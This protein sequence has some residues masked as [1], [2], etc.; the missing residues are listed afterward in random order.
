[1][2]SKIVT[3]LIILATL[4]FITTS[5]L[6][7]PLADAVGT[8]FTYQGRLDRDGQAYTGSCD[9]QFSLW[10][11]PSVGSQFGATIDKTGLIVNK[12]LFTT[13][14]DFGAGAFSGDARWLEVS[15]LC[16]G[17]SVYTTLGRQELTPTPYALYAEASPWSGLS[18]VPAG[19][20]DGVDEDTLYDNG[21]GLSLTGTTFSIDPAYI[22]RR[23][24][25]TCAAGSSIQSI[26]EDGT[27]T[28]EVD[29]NTTYDNGNGLDLTGTTFLINPTYTQRRVNSSCEAGS[30]IQ[31]IHEDGSIVCSEDAISN[32]SIPPSTHNLNALDSNGSVGWDTSVTVGV[33]GLGLISYRDS[34]NNTLKVAHCNDIN[35]LNASTYTLDTIGNVETYTSITIGQDGL[36]LVSYYEATSQD[37]RVAHCTDIPCS[38]V[39]LSTLDSSGDVGWDSSITIGIDGF[40]LISYFDHTNGDLKVAHCNNTDCTSATFYTIDSSGYVG[41]YTSITIGADG[42]GLISYSDNTNG[43]LKAAH[44]NDTL[45]SSA[46]VSI[47]DS[48]GNVGTYSSITTGVDGLGL[49]SYTDAN[50]YDIKVAHCNDSICS[51][52]TFHTLDST[53]IVGFYTSITIGSDGLGI[54]SYIDFDNQNLRIAHCLDVACT[55]ATYSTLDPSYGVGYSTSITIGADDLPL[56]THY[57]AYNTNL[58]VAHCSSPFCIPY[59]RRR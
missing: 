22:Q 43:D 15:V 55:K 11:A 17:E 31:V 39:T 40:A 2:K 51:T 16:S 1:M 34:G 33:D 41:A 7:A 52:A 35:C 47:L 3:I 44:C 45:C 19:F 21:I 20:L 29:V 49:I 37:L 36:G 8:A 4:L 57:D 30:T 5:S 28:C 48:S 12:G 23:V 25:S 14:L 56:I 53:G 10:D 50:N 24:S 46:T 42:R 32:R 54:M 38:N 6:A 27:V 26:A 18:G 9:F 13:Q 59:F 58:K